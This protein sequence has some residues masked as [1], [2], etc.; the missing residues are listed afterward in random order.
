MNPNIFIEY[1]QEEY[2]FNNTTEY[3]IKKDLE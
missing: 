2:A 1:N 3:K